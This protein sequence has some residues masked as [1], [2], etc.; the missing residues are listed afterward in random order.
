MLA[1]CVL[2]LCLDAPIGAT[3]D[4]IRYRDGQLIEGSVALDVVKIIGSAGLLEVPR[5]SVRRIV[6]TDDGLD[7]FLTDGSS[8]SG[9]SGLFEIRVETV[10]YTSVVP[11]SSVLEV[12]FEEAIEAEGQDMGFIRVDPGKK[13]VEHLSVQSPLRLEV[14]LEA[15]FRPGTRPEYTIA[16]LRRF[17]CD[18]AW[19]DHVDFELE[20]HEGGNVD[21]DIEVDVY[22]ARSHDKNIEIL[23]ELCHSGALVASDAI[24]SFEA[25]EEEGTEES[26]SMRV[27]RSDYEKL[28]SKPQD[29][30]LRITMAVE[31][32]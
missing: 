25:E 3:G 12:V 28:I 26:A 11:L 15:L 21:I 10:L 6:P 8:I 22:V 29:A 16:Y 7:L 27:S 4:I 9:R 31:D 5:K 20:K 17:K 14:P 32:D 23:L 19:I 2:S 30:T 1:G 13:Y 18:D 24:R